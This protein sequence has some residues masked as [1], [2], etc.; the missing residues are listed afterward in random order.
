MA[1][2]PIPSNKQLAVSFEFFPPKTAAME[3]TLWRSVER[4]AP[5]AP[6]FVSVTYGAG[7]STRQR[8]HATIA[9]ILSE[10]ALAPAA[11][12]TCVGASRAEIDSIIR[13]YKKIGVQ[14]IVA[15]RGDPPTGA[16]TRYEPHPD[17]YAG[18]PE[19]VAGIREIGGFA[20]SV[21]TY[22]EK[23]PDSPSLDADIEILKRKVDAGANEAITQFFF[24]SD[25]FEAYVEKVRAAGI[26]VPIVPGILP[27]HN[28]AQMVNFAGKAGA[29]VPAWLTDRFESVGDDP[30]EHFRVATDIAAGQVQDLIDRGFRRI[31]FYTLNRAALVSSVFKTLGLGPSSDQPRPTPAERTGPSAPSLSASAEPIVP[32]PLPKRD[33]RASLTATATDRIL[34]I[35]GAMGTMI[36][37]HKLDEAA[38]RGQR[39]VDWPQDLRGNNDVLNLTQPDIIGGIH[40]EYLKAGA[41][42][43]STNTFSSTRIAQADY[44]LG[45]FA[46]ELNVAGARIARHACDAVAAPDRPCFV[47]GALGPTNKTAS[48][49]A[50]VG[51]PG[52]REVS[53]DDLRRAYAEA[54]RGLIDGGAD[55]LLF[56]T[57]TD[58]LNVKAGNFAAEEVFEEKGVKL[59]I[60][61]SGT[62]TDRSGRTL[63]GQTPTALWHSVRHTRPLTMGL[64]CS[65]G[66]EDMRSY[67]AEIAR[68]ADT[69]VLAYPNA[70]LPNELGEYDETPEHMA[71][72]IGEFAK[73][74]L[75]NIVGGCCGTTPEHIA[76]IAAAVKQQTPRAIP[77]KSQKLRLSG[78]EPFSADA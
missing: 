23:H 33:A 4:L 30:N 10:T 6:D 2:D 25:D 63:S 64:N 50:D 3:E 17:G 42:I 11:H 55:L 19:L 39:F 9:R 26:D 74:G 27:I 7:G 5:L 65:L 62:I 38:F 77:T 61:I 22:P 12:L 70:G 43:L 8:T 69:L 56:E 76:A 31:H 47:A 53:F 37:K 18:T 1:P 60:M 40:P 49:S 72:T 68:E 78:L 48:M 20:I 24:D 32:T 34:I 67:I 29:V 73:S 15:L 35:D 51:N 36:Q 52:A 44:G 75:V 71:T 21:A 59:P 28:F 54:I 58:T 16:G 13:E 57:I 14:R 45:D 66:A 46:Y 41:D